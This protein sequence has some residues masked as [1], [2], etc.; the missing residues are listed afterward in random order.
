MFSRRTDPVATIFSA[1]SAEIGQD[2]DNPVLQ[3]IA[4]RSS[5]RHYQDRRIERET[6]EILLRAAMAAPSAKNVQPW[7][8]LVTENRKSMDE[9]AGVLPFG[10]M[11]RHAPLAIMVGADL[12]TAE[13]G[14][15]GYDY[16][17]LDCS[18]ATQNLLLAAEAV[19]LGAVWLGVTPIPD[20][21]ENVGRILELPVNVA[22]LCVIALGYPERAAQPKD[23]YDPGKIHWEKW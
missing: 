9:L 19:G 3:A 22:P 6:I 1:R 18:A 15:P 17:K 2:M 4:N 11:L 10:A 14:T 13:A 16:W 5:V 23:K 20:R 12:D 21:I 8:F 7:R